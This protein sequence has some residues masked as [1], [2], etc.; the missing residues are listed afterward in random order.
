MAAYS[1]N[2][3]SGILGFP[4]HDVNPETKKKKDWC[5]QFAKAID[6]LYRNN[7]TGIA[8]Q[9]RDLFRMWRLYGQG[10]QPPQKYMDLMGI[11]KTSTPDI[12][13]QAVSD[14]PT[15][16]GNSFARKGYM[17]INWENLSVAQNFKNVV[18]GTFEEIEHD[19]FAD[20]L[21][22]ASSAEREQMK[23]LL[24][25]EREMRDYFDQIQ[26]DAN[27]NIPTPDYIPETQKELQMFAELGGFKLRSEISIERAIS[28]TL[29][30]SEWKE[31]K[32]KLIMDLFDL[33]V[34]GSKDYIDPFSQK[35]KTRY[36][37]PEM[38]VIPWDRQGEYSNMPF[39]GE[40]IYYTI[41]EIRAL[42]D[43][44]GKPIFNEE[45]LCEIAR[46]VQ[47]LFGNT[48]VINSISVDA[49]GRYEY[50]S[51]KICVLDCEFKS[52]DTVYNTERT[53]SDGK[54]VVHKDEYGKVRNSEKRKTH[55]TKNLMVY[56]C[57]WILGTEF[58]W[59]YGH[60]FDIVRPTPSNAVLSFHFYK[61]KTGS[62][63]KRMIPLLDSIQLAWLKLQNAKAEAKNKGIAVEFTA[64][65]NV[66][67]GNN[68]LGPL[69]IMKIYG[70]KGDLI[71]QAT[72]AKSY[73]PAQTN[74]RPIQELAGGVG[75]MMSEMLMSISSDIEQIRGIIGISRIADA[76]SPST[77]DLVGVSEI[78]MAATSTSL[79]PMYSAYITI[80]ERTCKNVA[81]RVQMIIKFSKLYEMGY[82]RAFGKSITETLKIGSE[83]ENAM[84]GI[85]IEAR[86]NQQEK[87]QIMDAALESL[88][89]GR[90]GQPLLSNS[91]YMMIRNFVNLGMT[92]MAQAYMAQKERE[93]MA[94]ME[95]EKAAAIEQQ[96]QAVQQQIQAKAEADAQLVQL[97]MQKITL[98]EEEKRKTLQMEYGFKMEIK[99]MEL[100]AKADENLMNQIVEEN[101]PKENLKK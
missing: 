2:T 96:N 50:D 5:L 23:A 22:E 12:P 87:Q 58:A 78:S 7:L 101:K 53:T 15:Q 97:D 75:N 59:D 57:K 68:K 64:I 71:Y 16:G 6:S 19:V 60:Q 77:Q 11:D 61:M 67:M 62:Y 90:Q 81:L 24:W 26:K 56:R 36:C 18:L 91:D 43:T 99:K 1:N 98:V 34:A 85:R 9:D 47:G 80:K 72:A 31:I 13:N 28:Y 30:I 38:C 21:D 33:G 42:T 66:S 35:V 29:D 44:E 32:R 84:F 93:T 41:A 8:L 27:I 52:D 37:D 73:S 49:F 83:V 69:D 63:I 55:V 3:G 20:G 100:E 89:V 17:N 25:V 74:Y 70:Q 54:K 76:S 88:R 14:G 92:K 40:Y 51:F 79:R 4:S 39:A 10:N 95:E 46:L 94:R 45:E 86:P 48:S 82:V 65:T